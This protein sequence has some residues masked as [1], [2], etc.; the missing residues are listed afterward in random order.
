MTR[1]RLI[2]QVCENSQSNKRLKR[3][4][5]DSIIET[6]RIL[7][8]LSDQYVQAWSETNKS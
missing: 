2:K 8:V 5:I 3:I 1:Y 6:R 7:K 4:F